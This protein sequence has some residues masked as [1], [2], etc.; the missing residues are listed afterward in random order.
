MIPIKKLID[1][2]RDQKVGLFLAQKRTLPVGDDAEECF[3]ALLFYYYFL[4][5]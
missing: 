2:F 1:A 3:D 4:L 5:F